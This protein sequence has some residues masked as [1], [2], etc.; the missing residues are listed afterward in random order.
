MDPQQVS[1]PNPIPLCSLNGRWCVFA[2]QGS[3]VIR[4]ANGVANG[5]GGGR[6]DVIVPGSLIPLAVLQSHTSNTPWVLGVV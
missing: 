1:M 3:I 4:A 5:V 6:D 2:G